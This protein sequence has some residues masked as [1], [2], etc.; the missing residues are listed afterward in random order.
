MDDGEL[1]CQQG[2]AVH[3]GLGSYVS[4]QEKSLKS[5]EGEATTF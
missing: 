2:G 1:S 4:D 3:R 5:S